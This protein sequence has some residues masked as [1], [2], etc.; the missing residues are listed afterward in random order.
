MKNRIEN[1]VKYTGLVSSQIHNHIAI[2]LVKYIA[3]TKVSSNQLTAVSLV[4]AVAGAFCFVKNNLVYNFAGAFLFQFSYILDVADGQLARYKNQTSE[5]GYWLDNVFDRIVEFLAILSISLGIFFKTNNSNI[6]LL[7]FI[8]Y[9][10]IS[11]YFYAADIIIMRD[12]FLKKENVDNSIYNPRKTHIF[13]LVGTL[14][15]VSFSRGMIIIYLSFCQLIGI[16]KFIFLFISII[17]LINVCM[18]FFK[19]IMRR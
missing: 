6:L 18:V 16:S 9:F 19:E 17:G 4:V 2:F 14:P 13:Y 7:G 12:R 15:S 10:I 3:K 5:F 1:A 8:T 11:I